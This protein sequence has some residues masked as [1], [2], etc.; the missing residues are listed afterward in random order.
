M[1]KSGA[2]MSGQMGA[3]GYDFTQDELEQQEEEA[4]SKNRRKIGPFAFLIDDDIDT[5][6]LTNQ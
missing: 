2:N 3:T 1:Y 6:I 5:E 4:A